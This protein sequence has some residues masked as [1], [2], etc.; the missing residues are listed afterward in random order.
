MQQG[1]RAGEPEANWG[2]GWG[3]H[4]RGGGLTLV[5]VI[6]RCRWEDEGEGHS[7]WQE[8]HVQTCRVQSHGQH[9]NQATVIGSG[10]DTWLSLDQWD[11]I[12]GTLWEY[13]VNRVLFSPE[14]AGNLQEER[15]YLG[16]KPTQKKAEP[17]MGCNGRL[18]TLAEHLDPAIPE[19]P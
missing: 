8:Q 6:R 3:K 5:L 16:M 13:W 18:T 4:P 1:L 7:R 17:K 19:F 11:S 14:A 12:P 9:G 2:M 15:G 10:V